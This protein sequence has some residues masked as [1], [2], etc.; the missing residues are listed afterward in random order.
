MES[1]ANARIRTPAHTLE[2]IR[3]ISHTAKA[4]TNGLM[5]T[6]MK[7]PGDTAYFTDQESKQLSMEPLTMV[8]GEMVYHMAKARSTIKIR[9]GMR[10][11]GA[12]DSLTVQD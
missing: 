6:G 7:A 11:S 12:M 3:M 2:I 5:A 8:S 9:A 10:G 4:S 1:L